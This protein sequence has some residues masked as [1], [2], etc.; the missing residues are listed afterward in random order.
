DGGP[1][2][3]RV[4]RYKHFAL[5]AWERPANGGGG[6]ADG[7]TAETVAPG[8]QSRRT[9]I[10]A[11]C[12]TCEHALLPQLDSRPDQRIADPVQ[13]TARPPA[14]RQD[15]LDL[16]LTRDPAQGLQQSDVIHMIKG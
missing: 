8:G 13:R 10:Y 14:V 15:C 16:G 2:L 5:E 6:V 4:A 3:G 7:H 9:V 1:V 11:S 12:L